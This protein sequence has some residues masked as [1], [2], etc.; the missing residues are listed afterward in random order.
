[1]EFEFAFIERSQP[2]CYNGYP[3]S[4][5]SSSSSD[6]YSGKP[7]SSKETPAEYCSKNRNNRK[8][9]IRAGSV[10]FS[11]PINPCALF[12]SSPKPPYDGYDLKKP[13]R[14]IEMEPST[15]IVLPVT[16]K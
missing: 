9:T 12:V 1:M 11:L 13:V 5:D 16:G 6:G 15:P 3:V 7:L 4:S 8:K 14:R 10:F 2:S